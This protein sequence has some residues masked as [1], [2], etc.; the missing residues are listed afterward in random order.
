[1]L[2]VSLGWC[3][4]FSLPARTCCVVC[5]EQENI[6]KH[7]LFTELTEVLDFVEFPCSGGLFQVQKL[8]MT[9]V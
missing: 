7:V 9:F 6:L 5:R 8:F 4:V 3:T 1:M 2:G